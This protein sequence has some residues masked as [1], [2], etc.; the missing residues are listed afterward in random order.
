MTWGDPNQGGDSSAVPDQLKH[1]EQ[2]QVTSRA[3]AAILADGSV[4][5]WDDPDYGGDCSAVQDQLSNVRQ[6]QA[7]SRAFAAILADGSVVTL[8]RLSAD[9]FAIR[10]W[11]RNVK[12]VKQIQTTKA[13]FAAIWADWSVV[14]WGHPS[15]GGDSASVLSQLRN[16]RQFSG[17]FLHLLQS[18]R[19]DQLSAGAVHTPIVV[20]NV[21]LKLVRCRPLCTTLN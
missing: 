8:G 2:I 20:S 18:W 12:H 15:C 5:A 17:H 3:F 9:N 1:V 16:V 13:A 21:W 11:P 6:I 14:T 4:V 7:A 10:N 19:M